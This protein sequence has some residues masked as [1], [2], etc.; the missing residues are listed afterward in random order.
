MSIEITVGS[1]AWYGAILSTISAVVALWNIWRDRARIRTKVA[2]VFIPSIVNR[3][4]TGFSITASNFGRRGVLLDRVYLRFADGSSLVFF[5]GS[6]FVS[7]T[8]GLPRNLGEGESH[9]VAIYAESVADAIRQ[10]KVS[11]THAI[12]CDA[13]GREYKAKTSQ[14]FWNRVFESAP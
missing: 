13:L 11:P 3:M 9:T 10:Q 14:R 6:S 5:D 8:S 12:F 1:V 4:Q 2:H 7:G